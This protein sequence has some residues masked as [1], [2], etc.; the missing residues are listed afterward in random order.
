MVLRHECNSLQTCGS[1]ECKII[2]C[3]AAIAVAI[4][5]YCLSYY[6]LGRPITFDHPVLVLLVIAL[7]VFLISFAVIAF[8]T[9]ISFLICDIYLYIIINTG[10][11]K[12]WKQDR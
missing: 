3:I 2:S 5:Y 8:C 4:T 7:V 9:F 12:V 1:D 6:I 11:T 10:M